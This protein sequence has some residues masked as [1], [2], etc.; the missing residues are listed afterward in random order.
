MRNTQNTVRFM[1]FESS[2]KSWDDLFSEAAAFATRVGR[3]RLISISHS[4]DS[5]KGVV[6][7]WYWADSEG[8]EPSE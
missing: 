1:E 5:S 4:E 6:A 2:F 7:V 3:E 8:P